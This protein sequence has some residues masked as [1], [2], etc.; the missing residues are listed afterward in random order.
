[1]SQGTAE[2]TVYQNPLLFQLD[3]QGPIGPS[4]ILADPSATF[5]VSDTGSAIGADL[6]AIE[7]FSDQIVIGDSKPA[8]VTLAEFSAN[9]YL[10]NDFVN[11]DGTSVQIDIVDTSTNFSGSAFDTL[12]HNASLNQ[13]VY[14]YSAIVVDGNAP[15]DGG[16]ITV[17]VAQ[18]QSD[19]L[20]IPQQAYASGDTRVLNVTDT[21][22]NIAAYFSEIVTD[23]K[24]SPGYS[25][26]RIGAITVSD[27]KPVDISYFSTYDLSALS[28]MRNANGNQIASPTETSAIYN[29]S[30]TVPVIT[31]TRGGQA[32]ADTATLAPFANV[33]ISDANAGQTETVTVLQS[34][35]ANGTLADPNGANDGGAIV[36]GFYTL[37]GLPAAVSA[38]LNALIFKPTMHQVAAGNTVTTNFTLAITDTSGYAASDSSTGVQAITS[39][40]PCFCR[41][42]MLMTPSGE[43]TVKALGVGDL[44]RTWSGTDRRIVWVGSGRSLVTPCNRC[45][46]APVIIRAGA[47][48]DNIPVRD[49]HVTSR[50]QSRPPPPGHRAGPH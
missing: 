45:D 29:A 13:V 26:A 28:V 8:A 35:P 43:I 33:A 27:N 17:S 11:A 18:I 36:D 32:I 7:P 49:L 48:A 50:H 21:A 40:M 23:A 4:D 14:G 16:Y 25:P 47:L 12:E 9:S 37:S 1:M 15:A 38:E 2:I 30:A 44:V 3:V 41:G 20:V 31:G 19:Y 22:A 10:R 42:T 39:D 5:Y 24:G 34:N 46:V 6:P